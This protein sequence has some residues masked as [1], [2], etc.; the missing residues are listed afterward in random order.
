MTSI[1]I[2]SYVDLTTGDERSEVL[3]ELGKWT[4]RRAFPTVVVDDDQVLVGLDENQ[5]RKA[6]DI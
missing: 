4:Q 5:L 6:L 1:M 2:T 3:E